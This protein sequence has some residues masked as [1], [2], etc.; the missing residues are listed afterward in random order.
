MD[1]CPR[2]AATHHRQNHRGLGAR[3]PHPDE[4]LERANTARRITA[5]QWNTVFRCQ[6]SDA[7]GRGSLARLQRS[8]LDDLLT[9]RQATDLN[10]H[11][12]EG[13]QGSLVVYANSISRTG[14]DE[15]CER[16]SARSTSCRVTRL[17]TVRSF[18]VDESTKFQAG[19]VDFLTC[20]Y[21]MLL[22][23]GRT[24]LGTSVL[25]HSL[26]RLSERRPGK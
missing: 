12:K 15:K 6:C 14:Q 3:R 8:H 11:V 17:D 7:P 21:S 22:V 2:L 24:V 18:G 26:P 10:A 16:P 1:S 4:A 5:Q 20:H 19:I 25:A 9:F 13:E 23:S